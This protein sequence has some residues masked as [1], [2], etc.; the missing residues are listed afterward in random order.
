MGSGFTHLLFLPSSRW[1]LAT[2]NTEMI[3]I[4]G[5]I[6]ELF[7][8][9]PIILTYKYVNSTIRALDGY[10]LPSDCTYANIRIYSSSNTEVVIS[11]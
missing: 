3:T 5:F 10:L 2:S 11:L 1:C 6:V 4:S 8:W 7:R 9:N